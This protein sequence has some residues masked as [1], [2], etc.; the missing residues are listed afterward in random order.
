MRM[1]TKQGDATVQKREGLRIL[2]LKVQPPV[3]R[4]RRV[5]SRRVEKAHGAIAH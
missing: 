1:R 4:V 3:L 2:A 5:K